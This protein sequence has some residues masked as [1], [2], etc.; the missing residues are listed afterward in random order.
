MQAVDA[1]SKDWRAEAPA[2][3][4]E[5][6]K[7]IQV[8]VPQERL[9]P[10]LKGTY[11]TRPATVFMGRVEMTKLPPGVEM[12]P[13]VTRVQATQGGRF[14]RSHL[15][16]DDAQASAFKWEPQFHPEPIVSALPPGTMVIPTPALI[17][18]GGGDPLEYDLGRVET[19]PGGPGAEPWV[20]RCDFDCDWYE[21]KTAAD[22]PLQPGSEVHTDDLEMRILRVL[23]DT[24]G[25]IQAKEGSRQGAAS[26]RF[27]TLQRRDDST[28]YLVLY[29]PD[30]RTAWCLG[31]DPYRL[32]RRAVETHWQRALCIED[33]QH[34]LSH[35]DGAKACDMSR[36]RLIVLQRRY[37]GHS[38]CAWQSPPMNMQAPVP[39]A[40]DWYYENGFVETGKAYQMLRERLDSLTPPGPQ[41]SSSELNRYVLDVLTAFQS[42]KTDTVWREQRDLA[43]ERLRPFASQH[44]DVLL[45]LSPS[46][47]PD[48]Q[49]PVVTLVTELSTEAQ[50]DFIVERILACDW[51]AIVVQAKGW[52]DYA[53]QKML[54]AILA[55]GRVEQHL[56]TLM[57]TWNDTAVKR[58]QLEE[59]R[60]YPDARTFAKLYEVPA[61][62]PELD[63]LAD[64][65]WSAIAPVRGWE[66]ISSEPLEIA[67]S[68][69]RREAL[70]LALRW[71]TWAGDTSSPSASARKLAVATARQTGMNKPK[72]GDPRLFQQ[73]RSTTA[74]QFEYQP[75][76]RAWRVKP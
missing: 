34:V 17:T 76:R 37:L 62:R 60:V 56:R 1:R 55:R 40:R 38:Q 14:L 11:Q 70:D 68:Q 73:F 61:L 57:L 9:R 50:R 7:S 58:H 72:A 64:T 75:A 69:G 24:E 16:Q 52:G 49:S 2:R 39:G 47:V 74:N 54:P 51:L 48:E 3:V 21:W 12:I 65:L 45:A 30:K 71:S 41:A 15:T 8:T 43:V 28:P 59:L 63:R 10:I 44:L 27:H 25:K 53:R 19:E 67:V 22:V 20:L 31:R 4:A 13:H 6:A 66:N 46:A 35:M 23:A 33:A 5:L 36:L 29:A 18:N 32:A 26:L 42:L